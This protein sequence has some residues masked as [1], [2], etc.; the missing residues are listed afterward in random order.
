[1]VAP[2]N[3]ERIAVAA[4]IGGEWPERSSGPSQL[5]GGGGGVTGRLDRGGYF[6]TE[7]RNEPE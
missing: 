5:G 1:M 3:S 4:F 6:K 2:K 7:N